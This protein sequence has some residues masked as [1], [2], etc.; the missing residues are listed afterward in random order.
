M[1]LFKIEVEREVLRSS[2]FY[3]RADTEEQAKIEASELVDVLPEH[4][5]TED[6]MSSDTKVEEVQQK[7]PEKGWPVWSGGESG[8]WES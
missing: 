3:I 7:T 4:A 2:G 1:P 8:D 6:D 5:W